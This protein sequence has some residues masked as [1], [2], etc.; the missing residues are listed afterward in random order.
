M[1]QK[2]RFISQQ[3]HLFIAERYYETFLDDN[4]YEDHT[5]ALTEDFMEKFLHT[6]KAHMG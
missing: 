1:D 6:K 4:L 2:Q 5:I 3:D